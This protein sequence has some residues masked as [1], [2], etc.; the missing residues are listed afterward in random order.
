MLLDFLNDETIQTVAKRG[1][2]HIDRFDIDV[3]EE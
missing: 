2:G 3:L 1:T